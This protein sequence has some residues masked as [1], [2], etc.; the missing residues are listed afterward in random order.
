MQSKIIN[1]KTIPVKYSHQSSNTNSFV[2][3]KTLV[4]EIRSHLF[5]SNIEFAFDCVTGKLCVR[6]SKLSYKI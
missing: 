4:A 1:F 2:K 5:R 3:K 6:N